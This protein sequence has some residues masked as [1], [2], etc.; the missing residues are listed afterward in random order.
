MLT[1]QVIFIKHIIINNFSIWS[2]WNA[3]QLV[4]ISEN[5]VMLSI[6]ILLTDEKPPVTTIKLFAL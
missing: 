6:E 2:L 3:P 5:D 4:T 1:T